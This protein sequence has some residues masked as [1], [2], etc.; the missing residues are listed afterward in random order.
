MGDPYAKE[1]CMKKILLTYWTTDGHARSISERIAA[2]LESKG[3]AVEAVCLRDEQRSP[4]GYDAV[5]VGASIRYG[6]HH[7]EVQRYVNRYAWE[8]GSLPNAFFSTRCQVTSA[9]TDCNDS[10][11]PAS[12]DKLFISEPP[13]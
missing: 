4:A 2:R 9:L 13:K 5:M 7:P 12:M 10:N 6:F 3:A 11:R 8:L 1:L